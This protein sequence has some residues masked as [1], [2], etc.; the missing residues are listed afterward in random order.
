MSTVL[1]PRGPLPPR[2]YWF[3]RL[4]LLGILVV[5]LGLLWVWLAPG[6]GSQEPAGDAAGPSTSTP[7][8]GA[9]PRVQ[10]DKDPRDDET[11][12]H[13][14][15]RNRH[16]GDKG[17]PSDKEPGEGRETT[18]TTPPPAEPEGPC[19]IGDVLIA[20]DVPDG[21]AGSPT[22]ARLDFTSLTSPA[23][24]LGL[25][26]DLLV[27]RVSSPKRVVWSSTTCPALLDARQVVARPDLPGS[28]SFQW[29]GRRSTPH[30]DSPGPTVKPGEYVLEA[31][32]VGGE[33]VQ[34]TFVLS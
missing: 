16:G 8:S 27:L 14:R 17:R 22:Q 15:E 34:A 5:L 9:P 11:K 23:C 6:G 26:P 1:Q 20:L 24:T 30:C 3:R 18:P 13:K 2:V 32:L 33:P 12:K 31:A 19:E 25:T 4:A 7:T 28:Y 10:N 21:K 29:D